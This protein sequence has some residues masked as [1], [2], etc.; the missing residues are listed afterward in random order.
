MH[1][2]YG[3]GVGD[4]VRITLTSDLEKP[5]RY[6][7]TSFTVAALITAVT[8]LSAWAG[9]EKTETPDSAAAAAAAPPPAA[10]SFALAAEDGSWTGDITPGGIVFRHKKNDSLVFPANAYSGSPS[11]REYSSV[12]AGADTVR[13]TMTMA[14]TKCTDKA[15]KEYTHLVQVWLTGDVK[16]ESKGCASQK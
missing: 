6:A 2:G 7:R 8:T 3:A 4:R 14:L 5:M 9:G 15:G 13:I 16:L 11:L 1:F 10:E 12:F